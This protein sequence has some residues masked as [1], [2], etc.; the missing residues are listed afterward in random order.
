MAD[1]NERSFLKKLGT[2]FLGI[3]LI[4]GAILF[5]WLP[6]PGGI[7]MFLAGLGLLATNHK[8]AKDLLQWLKKNGEFIIEKFFHDHPVITALYDVVSV[9]LIIAAIFIF[10]EYTNNMLHAAAIVMGFVALGLFLGNRNRL[11]KITAW[12]RRQP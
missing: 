8:W 9:L 5:G 7:P 10:T 12:V 3:L 2:D 1:N 11:K 4:I 6:G